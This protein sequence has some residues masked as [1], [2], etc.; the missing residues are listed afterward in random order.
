MEQPKFY[1]NGYRVNRGPILSTPITTELALDVIELQ[2][3]H[4][5]QD[6]IVKLQ[7]GGYIWNI[8]VT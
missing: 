4:E 2:K 3:A 6:I 1:I 7:T 5:D 8:L